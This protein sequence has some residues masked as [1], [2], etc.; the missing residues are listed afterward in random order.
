VTRR[1]STGRI[2]FIADL[3]SQMPMRV[4]G[5]L[6]G[7]PEEDQEELRDA[8]D[9]GMSLEEGERASPAAMAG[10]EGPV[11]QTARFSKYVEWLR[12][13]PSDDLMTELLNARFVDDRGLERTLRDDE[14]LGY[15][16]LLAGAGNETTTRLIGWT[17]WLLDRFPDQRRLVA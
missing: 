17:A 10:A 8:I 5:M 7:I 2:D 11:D 1:R 16:G 6:L 15:I 13:H 9:A 12:K 14:L 4:I 3:G